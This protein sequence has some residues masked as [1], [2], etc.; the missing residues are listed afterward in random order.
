M[1]PMFMGSLLRKCARTPCPNTFSHPL[2]SSAVR[3]S[4][5]RQRR[6]DAPLRRR[7]VLQG[8]AITRCVS[9]LGSACR[10][11]PQG[12]DILHL[13]GETET[14]D[15]DGAAVVL[16]EKADHARDVVCHV[17]VE[18]EHVGDLE[19]T[20]LRAI[21]PGH[22]KVRDAARLPGVAHGERDKPCQRRTGGIIICRYGRHRFSPRA[23]GIEAKP[24]RKRFCLERPDPNE[25]SRTA[26]A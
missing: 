13:F 19:M 3:P 20:K 17:D 11:P 18:A 26:A 4:K 25:S 7:R 23:E 12:N 1:V 14:V 24:G 9:S 8:L 6:S 15:I 21:P 16:A 22:Q 10:W 5:A 2:L